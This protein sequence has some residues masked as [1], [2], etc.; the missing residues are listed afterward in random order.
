MARV[1]L[2]PAEL[3]DEYNEHRQN[4]VVT[5]GQ[6]VQTEVDGSFVIPHV[7]PGTYYVIASLP[8]YLSPLGPLMSGPGN[9]PELAG[10]EAKKIASSVPR[11]KVQ[12]NLPAS[13]NVS[14]ERGAAVSGSIVYDDGSPASGVEVNLLVRRENQWVQLPPNPF[15]IERHANVTDDQGAFRISGVPPQ[16]YVL[17][18]QMSI[19]SWE[20]SSDGKGNFG[21][22]F[23]GHIYSFSTYSG[24]KSRLKDARSFSVK[25]GEERRGEDIEIPVSKLHT[26]RGTVLATRDGHVINRALVSLIY[27]DDKT[28]ASWA[29]VSNSDDSFFQLNFVPEGDYILVVNEAADNDYVE[30]PDPV[31]KGFRQIVAHVLRSYGTARVSLHVEG[32]MAGVTINVPDLQEQ[33]TGTDSKHGHQPQ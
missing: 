8:G 20:Y 3:V 13:I 23:G 12:A 18:A 10:P 29:W 17:E 31:N 33:P 14:L 25:A 9:L 5:R 19:T 27:P 6:A 2:Q 28:Q 7:A 32:E 4:G 26:V 30:T 11:V 16:Q 21:S 22:S 24:N 1:L 15:Q